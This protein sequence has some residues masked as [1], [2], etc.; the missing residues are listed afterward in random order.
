MKL[1]CEKCEKIWQGGIDKKGNYI[2]R[3]INA[4]ELLKSPKEFLDKDNICH[5]CGGKLIPVKN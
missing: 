1:K 2:I 5:Y 3:L 4:T